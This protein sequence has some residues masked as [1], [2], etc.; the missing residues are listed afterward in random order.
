MHRILELFPSDQELERS[1]IKC[2]NGLKEDK[3]DVLEYT[4]YFIKDLLLIKVFLDLKIQIL[5]LSSSPYFAE[6]LYS[7]LPLTLKL[8]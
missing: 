2:I 7:T 4:A 5:T 8:Y 6:F 1:L 3:K